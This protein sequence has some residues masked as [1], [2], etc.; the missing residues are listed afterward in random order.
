MKQ[1]S[2]AILFV[3]VGLC[4]CMT[5]HGQGTFVSNLDRP[6]TGNFS[7]AADAWLATWFRTGTAS[8]GY[9]LD[10][11]QL[12]M[13]PASGT[14]QG[15]TVM[16]WDFRL[17]QSIAT[18]TGPTPLTGGIFTYTASSVRHACTIDRVLVRC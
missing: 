3:M 4:S 12:S 17:D 7:V 15:F 11:L 8:G 14:P 6:T 10:S 2:T 5:T 18:L 16:F 9:L 1:V 13:A